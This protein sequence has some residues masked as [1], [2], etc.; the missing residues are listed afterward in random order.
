MLFELRGMGERLR[1][2]C[3]LPRIFRAPTAI[4]ISIDRSLATSY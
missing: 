4:L 3:L 2:K 1:A